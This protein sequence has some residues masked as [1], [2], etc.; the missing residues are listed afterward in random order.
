MVILTQD[1]I[2]RLDYQQ[3]I[4]LVAADFYHGVQ[5]Y[6]FKERNDKYNSITRISQPAHRDADG[7]IVKI[8]TY[9]LAI[10]VMEKMTKAGDQLRISSTS[11]TFGRL[12]VVFRELDSI[13]NALFRLYLQ[14]KGDR[15]D[16]D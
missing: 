16:A 8:D 12:V 4:M 9:Q 13:P 7:F 11:I 3:L 6:A 5:M 1:E 2:A 10:F 14:W 15:H